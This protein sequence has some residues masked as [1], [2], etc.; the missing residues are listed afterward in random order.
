MRAYQHL[1]ITQPSRDSAIVALNSPPSNIIGF[2]MMG[3]L[4]ALL[5]DISSFS[6]VVLISDLPDFS[7]G[8]DVKIHTPDLVD[9]MLRDFHT[10]IRKLYGFE[11]MV[12]SILNGYALGGGLELAICSDLIFADRKAQLGFPE[13]KLACFPP[14][15][16]VLL[17]RWLGRRGTALVLSGENI[18]AED[19]AQLGLVDRIIDEDRFTVA[20]GFV[21]HFDQFSAHAVKTTKRMLRNLSG[22]DFAEALQ[23]AETVYLTELLKSNDP[24]E[25]VQAFLQKHPPKFNT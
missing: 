20:D 16:S 7:T 10:V 5:D 23:K 8:V 13:I 14:V 11:G 12:A 18:S 15:A 1:R 24:S 3:E 22:L 25:A 9:Q 4:N 2:E 17:P 21:P 19:A 6:C